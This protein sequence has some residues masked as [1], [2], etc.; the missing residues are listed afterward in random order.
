[1]KVSAD[2]IKKAALDDI[3]T[4]KRMSAV[5]RLAMHRTKSA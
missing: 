5:Y 2:F 3:D 4:G 1:M